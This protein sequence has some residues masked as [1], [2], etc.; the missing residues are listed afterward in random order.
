MCQDSSIIGFCD[1]IASMKSVTMKFS[2]DELKQ[3]NA[4]HEPDQ[5]LEEYLREL[6]AGVLPWLERPHGG[7]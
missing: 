1:N 6:L 5:T 3:L 7:H 4:M 2:D